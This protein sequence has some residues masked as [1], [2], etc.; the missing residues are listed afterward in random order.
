[1]A[2]AVC[3]GGPTGSDEDQDPAGHLTGDHPDQ[4]GRRA[5][6][7]PQRTVCVKWGGGWWLFITCRSEGTFVS[8]HLLTFEVYLV[9]SIAVQIESC[10]A[11]NFHVSCVW[12]KKDESQGTDEPCQRERKDTRSKDGWD[13]KNG[14]SSSLSYVPHV[15]I[16]PPPPTPPAFPSGFS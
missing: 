16:P 12:G 15:P 6:T 1:M 3:S 11:H 14:D 13:G 7:I 10:G 9:I 2:P 5:P 8:C 4:R